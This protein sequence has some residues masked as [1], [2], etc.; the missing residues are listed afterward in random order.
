MRSYFYL[1]IAIIVEIFATVML[2]M[3]DGFTVLFPSVGVVVGYALSFYCLSLCLRTIQLSFAYAIWSGAGTALTALL[4]VIL[5]EEV[6]DAFKVLGIILIIGGVVLLN[7]N[8]NTE[9]V[10]ESSR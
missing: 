5:W 9:T 8:T 6:F 2:K 3:S 4:G 10:R 1:T 7:S